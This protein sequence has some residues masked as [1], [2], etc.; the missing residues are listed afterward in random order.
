MHRLDRFLSAQTHTYEAALAQIRAGRKTSHWIW[1]IFPQLRGLGRSLN[2]FTFGIRDLEEAKEYLAHPVL[3]ARLREITQTLLLHKDKRIED[4]MG[5]VD[6]MKLRSS[7]TL[8][9]FVSEESSPFH[10][11]LDCFYDGKPDSRTLSMVKR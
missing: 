9:C 8:F 5:D 11:V 4:I 2:S 6:A 3:S 1:Y 10:Q 7:M